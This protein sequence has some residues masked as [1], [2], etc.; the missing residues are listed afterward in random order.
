MWLYCGSFQAQAYRGFAP[1]TFFIVYAVS[2]LVA[3]PAPELDPYSETCHCCIRLWPWIF[4]PYVYMFPF[5]GM[6]AHRDL[7]L[8]VLLVPKIVPLKF[9]STALGAHKSV[10]AV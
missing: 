2:I 5:G 6:N 3:R 1:C 8:L 10:C 9:I 4:A 7:V